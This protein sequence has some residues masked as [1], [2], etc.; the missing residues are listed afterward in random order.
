MRYARSLA[1][2][3]SL[4]ALAGTTGATTLDRPTLRQMVEQADY[5]F[6]GVVTDVVYRNST[7]VGPDD[8]DL[9]HTF[10]TFAVERSFKGRSAAGATIVLRLM[11]GL[12]A[13]DLLLAVSGV[14]TFEPG[15]RELLFVRGNGT[16]LCPLVGWEY[17][18]F[19]Q[20]ESHVLRADAELWLD[21]ADELA[22][23]PGADASTPPPIGARPATPGEFAAL[24]D[25]RVRERY[26][27][28]ELAHLPASPSADPSAPF[29]VRRFRE[30][31]PPADAG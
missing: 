25:R 17:G 7:V 22:G 13:D 31:A 10:V 6:E 4:S 2:V 27:D 21:A 20:D 9:P 18:R 19:N 30:H 1:L 16:D 28:D 15:D 3:A 26:G 24:V 29:R 14:P 23:P 11:G 5:V 8:V 12:K